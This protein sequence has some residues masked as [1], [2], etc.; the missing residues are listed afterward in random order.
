MEGWVRLAMRSR[1][2][3]HEFEP[4][5]VT[6]AMCVFLA[7]AEIAW[8]RPRHRAREGIDARSGSWRALLSQSLFAGADDALSRGGGSLN[9][10]GMAQV[11]A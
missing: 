10:R 7:C 1:D 9:G 11:R 5:A 2:G 8:R 4:R 3:V 6:L